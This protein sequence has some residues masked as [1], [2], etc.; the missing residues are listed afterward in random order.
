MPTSRLFANDLSWYSRHE[1]GFL[2]I[3][4]LKTPVPTAR[5]ANRLHNHGLPRSSL[6]IRPKPMSGYG[7]SILLSRR[8]VTSHAQCIPAL[9]SGRS[10]F[11]SALHGGPREAGVEPARDVLEPVESDN[12]ACFV[13]ADQIADPAEQ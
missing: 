9:E 13:K 4:R 2:P 6:E 11:Q 8:V 5:S 3:L 7:V 12:L 1:A 10:N